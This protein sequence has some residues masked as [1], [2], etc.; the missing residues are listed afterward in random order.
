MPVGEGRGSS[1]ATPACPTLR[2]KA[3]HSSQA[4]PSHFGLVG[5]EWRNIHIPRR[6]PINAGPS[7]PPR[8]AGD[9]R[10]SQSGLTLSYKGVWPNLSS[11]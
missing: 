10:G 6:T 11:P 3:F 5:W 2:R 4:S 1:V 8:T 9:K 7:V